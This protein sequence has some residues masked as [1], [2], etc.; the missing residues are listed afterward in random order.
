[1]IGKLNF[2]CSSCRP[3][4]SCAVHQCTRFSVDPRTN[5]TEAVQRIGRYLVDTFEDGII[6]DPSAHSF[7]V[8]ADAEFG[9]LW[10]KDEAPEN[11]IP[12]KSKTGYV[13]MYPNCP[14]IWASQ[15][16]TKIAMS[17]TEPEY[18]SLS[19]ALR[20]TIPLMRLIEEIQEQLDLPI[21]CITK[22]HCTLFEDNSGAVELAKVPKLR[23]RT[24]HINPK[25]HHFTRHVHEGKFK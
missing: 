1:V 15:L 13:I 6:L 24:K 22:V 12:S 5:H 25:Y 7:N 20:D 19:S 2:L 4:I 10:D 11:P 21:D 17:T 14:I 18:L 9:R 8:Y 3:E 23:P 16:Q